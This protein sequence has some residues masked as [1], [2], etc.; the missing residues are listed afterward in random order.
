MNIQCFLIVMIK[1]N[2]PANTM[3]KL[4]QSC[5]SLIKQHTSC[6]S[7]LVA[8]HSINKHFFEDRA[9]ANSILLHNDV[10]S[11]IH[12]ETIQTEGW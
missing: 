3:K 12:I 2:I 6:E 8:A 7:V 4:P 5:S 10:Q 9:D 11:F 1:M